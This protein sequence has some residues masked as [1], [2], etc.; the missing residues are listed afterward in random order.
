MNTGRGGDDTGHGA[1]PGL[2]RVMRLGFAVLDRQILDVDGVAVGKVDDVELSWE[3]GRRPVLSALLTDTGA[4]GPRLSGRLGR[5]WRTLLGRL[6]PSGDL[7]VRI[8]PD[9]VHTFTPATRLTRPAPPQTR[10]V[11]DW[12]RTHLIERIPGGG[13]ADSDGQ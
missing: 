9:Q 4:L 10:V 13:H 2:P 1:G 11:E 8:P 12:L 5:T 7:P 3:E 6:R